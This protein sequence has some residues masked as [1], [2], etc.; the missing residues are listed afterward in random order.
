MLFGC[1]QKPEQGILIEGEVEGLKVGKL[2]LQQVR[3]TT[4]VNLDSLIV[5]GN[6]EFS[7]YAP[8]EE[9]QMLYLYLDKKDR[10]AYDDRMALFTDD[11]TMVV[12]TSL[13]A[14]EQAEVKGS[15]NHELYQEFMVNK[16]KLDGKQVEL[17]QSAM[18]LREKDTIEQ[19]SLIYLEK[20]YLRLLES[21]YRYALNFAQQNA[22]KEVAP[23]VLLS[24][25]MGANPVWLDSIYRTM[26]PDVQDGLYGLELKS[27]IDSLK[28]NS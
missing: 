9:P 22:D 14:F 27:Q 20:E 10:S 13:A 12:K 21:K 1:S 24:E 17:M 5:D 26:S 3:D 28:K 25:A 19:D 6:A 18:R 16:R 11:S 15:K 7:F 4:L 2:Y 8:I 23:Y